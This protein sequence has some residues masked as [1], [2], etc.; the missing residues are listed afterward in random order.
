MA[1]GKEEERQVLGQGLAEGLAPREGGVL[2]GG[3]AHLPLERC[4][5]VFSLQGSE[6]A[7]R[8]VKGVPG[9]GDPT[10]LLKSAGYVGMTP[11]RK[12]KKKKFTSFGSMGQKKSY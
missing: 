12:K 7:V 1:D 4:Q 8:A 6:R 10:H 2:K 9:V 11:G 5:L 3:Q